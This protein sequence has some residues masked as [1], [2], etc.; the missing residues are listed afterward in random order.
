[1]RAIA[2][3]R[4]RSKER[5]TKTPTLK[6]TL[7]P[8]PKQ[9]PTPAGKQART[10][11]ATSMR[12]RRKSAPAAVGGT[13]HFRAYLTLKQAVLSGSFRPSQIVT[14][15]MVT[16]LLGM[17][18]MPA[19]EALKRLISEGAFKAMPNRSAR[20]PVLEK[21]EII[22]LCELRQYLEAKAAFLA[23]QNI[24][25][26]QIEHLRTFHEGMIAA[27]ATGDLAEYKRLNMAFHFEIYRIAHNEPLE[28]LID[29][30]WLRMAPFISRTINWLDTVPGRFAEIANCRHA[31]ILAAF[32]N[33]D[34]EAARTAM[35]ADLSEIHESDGYWQSYAD[36]H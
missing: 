25:L 1:V 31:E 32:Q 33:R 3:K 7:I 35:H 18:E 4:S 26:H 6:P 13:A 27:V 12:V 14:L 21:K 22:Q 34:A 20:V 23:A 15:R 36:I 30:L 28:S 17:G 2:K 11:A 8:T 5:L 29:T 16:E 24:S 19:R 9:A 10:P